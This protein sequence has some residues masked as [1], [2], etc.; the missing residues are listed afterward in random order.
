MAEAAEALQ[1]E[2]INQEERQL[3]QR[4]DLETQFAEIINGSMRTNFELRLNGYDLIGE[5][6]R[7]MRAVADK[8]LIKAKDIAKQYPKL[9]FEVRRRNLER[10]EIHEAI[11]MA[12][13]E[14]LNTMVVVSDFPE[15]LTGAQEDVGGY[16]VTRKQTM[17]RILT[18]QPN[19]NIQMYSQSLDGSNREALEAIY[20]H[21]GVKPEAG[22]LLSQRLRVD[23]PWEK[24]TKLIDELKGVYDNSLSEQFGG[25]WYAGR[26]PADYR[27][28]Y[29]FVGMQQDLIEE[30]LRLDKLGWLNDSVMYKMSATMQK[31]FATAQQGNIGTL[32]HMASIDLAVLHK[33]IELAGTQARQTGASFSACGA[34]LRADGPDGSTENQMELA[35]YGNK[36]GEDKYGSL[37]FKCQKGHTNTRPR[38]L[39]IDKCKTCGINVRC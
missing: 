37:T 24:Q 13:G 33:E 15:E 6:G 19:G 3:Q 32:P 1:A 12:H 16:N 10:D 39:L 28:T 31:R 20:A 18:R 21:F 30:C 23:L 22:E 25:E 38:N 26:R 14:G 29:E 17:L 9:W 4:Y 7:S 27:N 5:D 11:E 8:S 36:T 2:Y 35:G 34:T